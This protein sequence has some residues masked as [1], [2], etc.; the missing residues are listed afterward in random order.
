[1]FS[2]ARNFINERLKWESFSTR[3]Y[4]LGKKNCLRDSFGMFKIF[5]EKAFSNS[6]LEA[7][8]QSENTCQVQR[9]TGV[10]Y[11]Q[12]FKVIKIKCVQ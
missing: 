12:V 7:F 10:F 6:L 2:Q 5:K 11:I 9:R 1:M 8:R 4:Q 3:K